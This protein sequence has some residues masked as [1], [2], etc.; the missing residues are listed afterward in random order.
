MSAHI[1]ASLLLLV[2]T[3][4]ICCVLYPLVL[5][6]IGQT[7]FHNKAEGSLIDKEGKPTD[8][9]TRAVGSRLIGQ[10]FTG[11]EYFQP[12]P[13]AT[14]PAYNAAAS[15]ASNWAAS[16]YRLRD[17]VA[18]LLGPIVRYGRGAEKDGKKPGDLVAPDI[19]AWF[20]KGKYQG[21]PGIVKQWAE[22]H[23]GLAEDWVKSTG[24]AVKEQWN[25]KDP[26]EAFL[27][28][29]RKDL[30]E[31]YAKWQ[32]EKTA[33]AE[34]TAADL[35]GPFFA[36]LSAAYPGYWP[37]VAEEKTPAGKT[38]KKLDRAKDGTDVQSA[39]F[40]MWRQEHPDV[41][42]E[43]VPADMVMASGSGLDPHITLE[44]A[45]YQLKYRVAD[46]Q[47]EKLVKLHVERTI[48]AQGD[49]GQVDEAGRKKIE[50]QVR[51]KLDAQ[52]GKPLAQKVREVL[53]A[54]LNEKQEA[55]LG[56][57]VGVP[58]VNVLEV[59]LAMNDRMQR[60]IDAGK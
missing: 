16:N 54:L 27:A 46:A 26:V 8:D 3:L 45:R 18:R 41:S 21:K 5:W 20:Q 31:L 30:P 52:V 51:G 47:A 28:Q 42:L 56:G 33:K 50:E 2:A 34:P 58:L 17:R 14:T 48:K 22:M 38:V 43:Q 49:A 53:E 15:G 36:I 60:L 1:R 29:W 11:D 12:R 13:S 39:F 4:V 9:P 37:V 23:S 57:L 32:A 24:D 59:N 25:T 7:V 6:G 19:E 40:D 35:A 44:N 10:P 55:P